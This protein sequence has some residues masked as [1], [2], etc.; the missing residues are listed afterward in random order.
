[1]NKALYIAAI[2]ALVSPVTASAAWWNPFS[3]SANRAEE[4]ATTTDATIV[5][6]QARIAQLESALA[7]AL[8]NAGKVETRVETKIVEVPAKKSEPATAA[9]SAASVASKV[10]SSLV[11][12]DSPS[13]TFGGVAVD[14]RNVL[15]N[16]RA[17]LTKDA[18]VTSGFV[19]SVQ[20]TMSGDKVTAEVMG[21][22]EAKGVAIVRMPKALASA[23]VAAAQVGA[24][25]FAFGASGGQPVPGKV[26]Q[27]GSGWVEMTADAI[28]SGNG[29]AI[30]D[31]GGKVI[32]L[33]NSSSC[34][35][36][37]E[38]ER[39]L[40][41][42]LSAHDPSDSIAKMS[43]GMRL[44]KDRKGTTTIEVLVRGKLEGMKRTTEEG[45]LTSSA[46]A[47]VTGENSFDNF[48]AKLSRDGDG[49]ITKLYLTKLMVAA[50]RMAKAY[51]ALENQAHDTS[52]FF[53]DNETAID[54]LGGYQGA[55]L[56]R[57]E[58]WNSAKLKLYRNEVAFWTKKRNEYDAK[59]AAP[60]GASHDYLMEEGLF[61][62][63][64][65]DDLA[66]ERKA[67]LDALSGET[68]L[69]F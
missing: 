31:A 12:I 37:E 51:D 63:E 69:I 8:A 48:N 60:S 7:D 57:V 39:C 47:Y 4:A 50:D 3:W 20:A 17:V 45:V 23:G 66:A 34:R 54:G 5:A 53:I 11:T 46:I 30:V 6:L 25:A 41:Y 61:V 33:A 49:K 68:I 1:M 29:G 21:F 42:K 26:S 55:T 15:V 14:G 18:G 13:G 58:S 38:S 16:A 19:G 67:I 27:K 35:V 52:V 43:A 62:E 36:V 2:L 24:Q 32:G 59:I 56:D 10:A 40:S 64:S 9:V 44:Y 22:D 28:P 65:A